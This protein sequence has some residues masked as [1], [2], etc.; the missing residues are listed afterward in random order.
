[1][2][3]ALGGTESEPADILDEIIKLS[4]SYR[5]RR[6][7]AEVTAREYAIAKQVSRKRAVRAL[8]DLVEQ[9]ELATELVLNDGS[10]TRVW[11]PIDS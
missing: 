9:G 4:S 10:V 3:K 6:P 5:D 8:D 11:W 1:M 7:D 2:R